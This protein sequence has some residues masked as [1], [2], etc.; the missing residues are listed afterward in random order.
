MARGKITAV[1][2]EDG[3]RTVKV[4]KS[5]L[6]KI[7]VGCDLAARVSRMLED[8]DDRDSVNTAIMVL[9]S[10]LIHVE[11]GTAILQRNWK[12]LEHDEEAT[13]AAG[14]QPEEKLSNPS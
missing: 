12:P 8:E 4:P 11:H 2:N 13:I 6:D 14:A 10:L 5:V 1:L 7:K 3:T 9:D